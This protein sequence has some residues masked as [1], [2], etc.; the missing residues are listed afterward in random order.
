LRID[1][2]DVRRHYMSISD[3]ELMALDREE[4]TDLARGLYDQ[5]LSRRGLRPG[6]KPA[7]LAEPDDDVEPLETL[8]EAEDAESE[9]DED[10]G[11]ELEIDAGPPP[12]WIDNA[13]CAC[14]FPA[15]AGTDY[16]TYAEAARVALKSAG[17]PCH[18]TLT[19][20]EQPPVDATTRSEYWVMVPSAF[21]LHAT[22]V[23]DRDIFNARQEEEWRTHLEALSDEELRAQKPEIL[24]AGLLDRV[25]R[26]KRAYQE[27]VA[28]RGLK[29]GVRE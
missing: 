14:A 11:G 26:L 2:E 16:G 22:S 23:L 27:E 1:P 5:E 21:N 4:L 17:I 9:L 8:G 7:R 6:R 13:A 25:A 3:E 12:D 20:T 10:S 19:R 24:C 18:I 28:R 29:A 15:V